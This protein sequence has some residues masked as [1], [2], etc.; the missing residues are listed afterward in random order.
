[1]TFLLDRK[2]SLTYA[3]QVQCQ[4]E[5]QLVAGRLH[6]GDRLPSVR[7][8]ARQL[9][10]S[11]TTAE[12]IHDSLCEAT[13][14]EVRP[15]SGVFVAPRQSSLTPSTQWAHEVYDFVT[16]AVER[17]RSLG[18]DAP[19]LAQLIRAIA[20]DSP[21]A[22]GH[23][24]S[25]P[26]VATQDT[27]ECMARCLASR[28]P[29]RFVQVSPT[30]ATIEVP[31]RT[32]Y[33]LSGYYMR[34]EARK[35]AEAL[36]SQVIYVRYNVQLLKKA[37]SIPSNEHRHFVTRDV[38][39]AET[40]KAFLAS[41]FPEVA[42]QRYAVLPVVEWLKREAASLKPPTQVWATLTAVDELRGRVPKGQLRVLHPLL[43]EDFLDEL[44]CLAVCG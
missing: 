6:P 34:Q 30:S 16:Q 22:S 44:R 28:D 19:R 39:N 8:L 7:Q 24:V 17:G 41:A 38:D 37:M 29:I 14:A 2:S 15:R 23:V 13:L 42:V 12:R 35:I 33:V 27:C 18:L 11:R 25:F 3:A 31:R 4:A 32:R 1:M 10:I 40:T 26:V 20:E 5:A 36:G 21:A 43:A 9:R